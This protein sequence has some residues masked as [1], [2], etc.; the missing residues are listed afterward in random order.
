MARDYALTIRALLAKADHPN[1]P[2]AE[3]DNA[4]AKAE[5]LMREYRVA[6]EEALA[7]DPSLVVPT[8]IVIEITINSYDISGFFPVMVRDLAAHCQ[9]RV[10]CEWQYRADYS[11]V[12]RIGAVGYETDLRYFEFLLTA[13]QLMFSTKIDVTWDGNLTEAE[14][15]YRMRQ[16][17]ILR[18][19]IADKAWGNSAGEL[20]SNRSKVQRIYLKES[21]SRGEDAMAA[22]LDFN[23]KDYRM[24]YADS[25]V[26]TLRRRLRIARDAADSAGGLPVHK[27]RAERVDEAFYAKYPGMKP[28]GAVA[29]YVDPRKDCARC[30]KAASGYCREHN[31][32]KPRG[33]SQRDELAWQKKVHGSAS[34]SG[35]SAGESA[36]EGVVVTRGHETARRVDRANGAL[37]G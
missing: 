35:R 17:G 15:I 3:A 36:A 26:V 32:L 9:V 31:Y 13:A 14:N 10:R 34:R 33:W 18:K 27:G 29:E 7:A 22:G 30:A 11:R 12:L 25:F 23:S 2:Q 4:R 37:E 24:A 20:A 21:A 28:T 16:A 5:L 1:T 6:E 19:E 8:E